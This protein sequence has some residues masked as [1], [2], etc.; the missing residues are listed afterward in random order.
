MVS[1]IWTNPSWITEAEACNVLILR[2]LSTET[3]EDDIR[4]A[5]FN[6]SNKTIYDVRLVKDKISNISRGFCFVELGSK[7]V[8]FILS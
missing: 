7:E 5:V 6:L 2:G 3:T 8:N 4:N 1:F